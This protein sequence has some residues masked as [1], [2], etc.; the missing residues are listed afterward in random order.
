MTNLIVNK[1]CF[2]GNKIRKI[3][4]FLHFAVPNEL[5]NKKCDCQKYRMEKAARFCLTNKLF[6]DTII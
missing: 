1:L 3:K 6:Y 5:A 4:T 2:F